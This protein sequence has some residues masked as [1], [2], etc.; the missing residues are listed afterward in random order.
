MN[1]TYIKNSQSQ[2]RRLSLVL[3][4]TTTII[5]TGFAQVGI[6]TTYIRNASSILDLTA[7]DK[8]FIPPRM[9]T[10]QQNGISNPTMG[11]LIYNTDSNCIV[12]YRGTGWFSLC[13]VTQSLYSGTLVSYSPVAVS[14]NKNA[15]SI[16][17]FDAL[18]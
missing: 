15:K 8:G 6:G 9:N 5:I 18:V 4:F 7:S 11:M 1:Y 17:T 14:K 12:I 16:C 13:N 3:L 10:T 2:M